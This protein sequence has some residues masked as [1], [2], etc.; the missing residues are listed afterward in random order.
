M[1][2]CV[3]KRAWLI[4]QPGSSV[5]ITEK[6]LVCT[7]VLSGFLYDWPLCIISGAIRLF[8]SHLYEPNWSMSQIEAVALKWNIIFRTFGV[9]GGSLFL[10][11]RVQI[12]LEYIYDSW[13]RPTEFQRAVISWVQYL[14]PLLPFV[15]LSPSIFSPKF[16]SHPCYFNVFVA[17]NRRTSKGCLM[18]VALAKWNFCHLALLLRMFR[19]CQSKQTPYHPTCHLASLLRTFMIL[20][21]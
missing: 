17:H 4:L 18:V 9:G 7:A 11:H 3:Y 15:P 13:K 6:R 1:M 16:L 14:H 20:L 12:G 8:Y 2:T 10:H 21:A 19:H 5:K